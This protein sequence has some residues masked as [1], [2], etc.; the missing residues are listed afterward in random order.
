MGLRAL[1]GL[2]DAGGKYL[3]RSVQLDGCPTV[4]VPVL[5]N[6]IHSRYDHDASA[7]MA[8][9]MH[10]D[11]WRLHVQPATSG[12]QPQIVAQPSDHH[13]DPCSGTIGVDGAG[14]RQW[15]YLLGGRLRLHVYLG[16]RRLTGETRWE[17]WACWSLH[18]LPAL[19]YQELLDVQRSGYSRQ[20]AANSE[21]T[22][23]EAVAERFALP[24]S[25]VARDFDD[26][27][28]DECRAL[29]LDRTLHNGGEPYRRTELTAAHR[30]SLDALRRGAKP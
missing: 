17:P 7:A 9:L 6:L 1:L 2:E 23:V 10:G 3:A 15:A 30:R 27:S 28:P 13:S 5:T 20:W 11:W 8:Q 29:G 12:H 26:L 16:V 18:D 25:R 19:P 4:I 22:Y 21:A 24:R 14:D